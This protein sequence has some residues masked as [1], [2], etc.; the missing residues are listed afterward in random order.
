MACLRGLRGDAAEVFGRHFH[1]DDVTDFC[2]RLDSTSC[3]LRNLVLRVRDSLGHDQI[4]EGADLA[5][6]RD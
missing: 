5:G 6:L 3:G 4:G 1:F 2:V